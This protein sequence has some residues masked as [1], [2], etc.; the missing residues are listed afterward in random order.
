MQDKLHEIAAAYERKE[1]EMWK[2]GDHFIFGREVAIKY[3]PTI[4][5]VETLFNEILHG[6]I[7]GKR[8]FWLMGCFIAGLYVDVIRKDDTITLYPEKYL[9]LSIAGLGYRHP[10]G[11]LEIIGNTGWWTGRF[12]TGGELRIRGDVGRRLGAGM[13]GGRIVA[14]GNAEFGVGEFMKGGEIVVKGDACW[15]GNGMRGGVIRI[16]GE[17]RLIAESRTG[18]EIYLLRDGEWVKI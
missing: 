7:K 12:M 3:N 5:D 16:E 6:Y 8:K 10:R 17:C 9:P 13:R 14:E 15:I 11:T 1:V 18:G 2:D 4:L